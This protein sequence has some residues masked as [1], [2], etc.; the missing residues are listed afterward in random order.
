MRV[1]LLQRIEAERDDFIT[2]FGSDE[3]AQ[4]TA[5]CEVL[6]SDGMTYKEI[7]EYYLK[8]PSYHVLDSLRRMSERLDRLFP[9][10]QRDFFHLG[11]YVDAGVRPP[12]IYWQV[13]EPDGGAP[14]GPGKLSP[15]PEWSRGLPSW[16]STA[17]PTSSDGQPPTLKLLQQEPSIAHWMAAIEKL[18]LEIRDYAVAQPEDL[19]RDIPEVSL[20]PLEISFQ[21]QIYPLEGHVDAALFL[22]AVVDARGDWVSSADVQRLDNWPGGTPVPARL[23]QQLPTAVQHLLQSERRLGTR[24]VTEYVS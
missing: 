1:P 24:F 18:D 12:N 7:A 23:I 5:D 6:D 3:H 8:L 11:R 22:Q 19:L 4:H 10:R 20:N 15:D 16:L 14:F 13:L 21:G 9:R 17:F 2:N